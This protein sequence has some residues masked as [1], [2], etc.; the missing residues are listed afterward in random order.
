L[1]SPPPETRERKR[2]E[3]VA[4]RVADFC[5]AYGVGRTTAYKLAAEGKI[6]MLR[7]G[8][9][10]TVVTED[11][12]QRWSRSRTPVHT[13]AAPSERRQPTANNGG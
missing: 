9:R 5:A 2:V 3:P 1:T 4:R 10:H 11:S 8:A 7:M 12:A 6:V 13:H